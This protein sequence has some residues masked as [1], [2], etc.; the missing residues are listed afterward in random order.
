M[1]LITLIS[2][3]VGAIGLAAIAKDYAKKNER[4][5]VPVK[6]RKSQRRS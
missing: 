6:N 4:V 5:P 1:D 3:I 2:G